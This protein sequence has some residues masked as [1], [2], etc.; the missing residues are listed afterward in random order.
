[1]N[2]VL[3]V[4]VGRCGLTAT[5][6]MLHAGGVPCVGPPPFFEVAD[7]GT[8][9]AV[10]A[11]HP[12]HAVKLVYP[13]PAFD[14]LPPGWAGRCVVVTRRDAAAQAQSQWKLLVATGA[15]PADEPAPDLAALAAEDVRIAA[16]LIAGYVARTRTPPA[17]LEFEQILSDPAGTA[18]ALATLVG[19]PFDAVK[20]AAA[21][22]RRPPGCLPYMMEFAPGY[23]A[24]E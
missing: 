8:A 2:T 17:R 13:D 18:R 23:A 9:A 20:A 14:F 3:V 11:A 21:V 6:Q 15:V 24:G 7:R 5:M 12:G 10:V 1:M 4:G 22:V 19:G 16:A